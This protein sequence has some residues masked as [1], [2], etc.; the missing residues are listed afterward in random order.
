MDGGTKRRGAG[1]LL[2]GTRPLAARTHP[3]PHTLAHM[4]ISTHARTDADA[5]ICSSKH[6]RTHARTHTHTPAAAAAARTIL[7][8]AG[9]GGQQSPQPFAHGQ[10]QIVKEP[11]WR[12]ERVETE[13]KWSEREFEAVIRSSGRTLPKQYKRKKK[14]KNGIKQKKRSSQPLLYCQVRP[15]RKTAQMVQNRTGKNWSGKLRFCQAQTGQN[16]AQTVKIEPKRSIQHS[17]SQN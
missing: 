16:R 14:K 10:E 3:S 8:R 13:L 11:K 4:H 17:N 6:K 9:E 5:H 2:L 1:A 15:D 7:C 12:T